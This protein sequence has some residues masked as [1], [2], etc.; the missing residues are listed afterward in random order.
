MQ[1]NDNSASAPAGAAVTIEKDKVLAAV[2]R[3]FFKYFTIG[4]LEAS[5]DSPSDMSVYEPKNVKQ[6][7]VAHIE[8]VSRVFNQEVFY[9]ISRINYA[10]DEL[11]RELQAFVSA[12]N[13]A[14]ALGLMRFACR[15]QPFYDAMVA[16]YKRNFESLLCGSFAS[17]SDHT[18]PY[19]RFAECGEMPYPL[20]E[21]I[22]NRI[23]NQAYTEGKKIK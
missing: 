2:V 17:T 20:A 21:S 5:T 4:V 10:E 9:A 23:A 13:A 22:I 16:E 7:M 8:D 6:T 18:G 3:A 1:S 14:D 11:E 19:T 15:T 12:G